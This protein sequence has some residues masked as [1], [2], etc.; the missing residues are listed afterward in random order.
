M[1]KRNWRWLFAMVPII[2]IAFV[3]DPACTGYTH[4]LVKGIIDHIVRYKGLTR[5]VLQGDSFGNY[6]Y[7]LQREIADSLTLYARKGDQFERVQDS[8]KIIRGNNVTMWAIDTT[9]WRC[10]CYSWQLN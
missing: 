6:G 3:K 9:N 7:F 8:I 4:P 1:I 10:T 5:V 2:I